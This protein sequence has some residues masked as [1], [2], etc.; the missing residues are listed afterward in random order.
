MA[1]QASSR[2]PYG[3][4]LCSLYQARDAFQEGIKECVP[5]EVNAHLNL[6]ARELLLAIRALLDRGLQ[7]LVTE[8]RPGSRRKVQR[9]KVE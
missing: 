3:C 5:L 9:V 2:C 4:P 7:S 1:K 6:A 8:A